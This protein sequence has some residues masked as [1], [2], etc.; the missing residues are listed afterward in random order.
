M[1]SGRAAAS[2]LTPHPERGLFASLRIRS[3]PELVLILQL[4]P[5]SV[6][7]IANSGEHVIVV[8]PSHDMWAEV[9]VIMEHLLHDEFPSFPGVVILAVSQPPEPLEQSGA[10]GAR[11]LIR[12]R[13]L[14]S[15]CWV[16]AI[17]GVW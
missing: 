1:K 2:T 12:S 4:T 7:S 17:R 15:A 6:D 5:P 8:I 16:R 3:D 13:S 14:A 11:K 9:I 10:L